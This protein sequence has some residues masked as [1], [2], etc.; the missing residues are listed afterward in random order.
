MPGFASRMGT[1]KPSVIVQIANKAR[2]LKASGKDIISFSIGVPN[3]LPAK[4]I[5]DAAHA[6]IDQDAGNYLPCKGSDELINAFIGRLKKDGFDYKPTEVCASLGAKN[7][8]FNLAFCLLNEGDEVI[9]PTPFWSSYEDMMDMTGAVSV[10]VRCGSEQNYKMT[11]EQLEN[12]ITDKTKLL[13]FNNPSNPTG[14]VYT[15]DEIRALGDVI[16]KHDIW[17]ISDDIYDKM[18]FDGEK[19]HHLLHTHP[20]LK[21]RII[22]VQS[23]SKTYGMPGWRVG[24]A[25]ATE[26]IAQ[27]LMTMNANT[28]MNVP[29]VA[30][31]AAAAAFSG[32]HGF[33]YKER[34]N[35]QKKRDVVLDVL[36]SI[37]GIIC[38]FPRGAF[39]AFPDVSAYFGKSYKGEVISNDEKLAE[40]LLEHALVALV[41]GGAFG[42]PNAI[43]ISYACPDDELVKGMDRLKEF[44]AACEGE[45]R[46]SA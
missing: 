31:A 34:D 37:D 41:P 23:I 45:G 14:M 4:H 32:D 13:I 30:M 43:R 16:E 19:F 10:H 7:S 5:Y 29:A 42:E 9:L 46:L 12:A 2:E 8:L 22:I 21:D 17:V 38:P 3:F 39:Y 24:M 20:Q 15:E 18:V 35:F 6:S 1:V 11:A 40:M 26:E 25:A 28:T 36:N 27:K 33:V 44:F